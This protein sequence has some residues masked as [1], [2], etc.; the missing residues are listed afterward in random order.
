MHMHGVDAVGVLIGMAAVDGVLVVGATVDEFAGYDEK[1]ARK[2]EKESG[3][4][5]ERAHA[6]PDKGSQSVW[7]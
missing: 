1:Q 6:D 3:N 7:A 2:K 4:F 5:P